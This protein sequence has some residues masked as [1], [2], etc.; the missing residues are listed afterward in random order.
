[1][2][3]GEQL[4]RQAVG[5]LV[6][7]KQAQVASPVGRSQPTAESRK[8]VWS[9]RPSRTW[10]AQPAS[11]SWARRSARGR[12]AAAARS[13]ARLRSP[14]RLRRDQVIAPE[15]AW[16]VETPGGTVP[17]RRAGT[18]RRAPQRGRPLRSRRSAPRARAPPRR[19]GV[20]PAR[21]WRESGW[22]LGEVATPVPRVAR[23]QTPSRAQTAAPT[24]RCARAQAAAAASTV[25]QT[26]FNDMPAS[27]A[28]VWTSGG[29]AQD[30]VGRFDGVT[31]VPERHN[32]PATPV[33]DPPR[34]IWSPM[35]RRPYQRPGSGNERYV[36]GVS[37]VRTTLAAMTRLELPCGDIQGPRAPSHCRPRA[38]RRRVPRR[39]LRRSGRLLRLSGFLITGLLL[40]EAR[41]N[42]SISLGGFYLRRARRSAG[43][44]SDA[45][46]NAGRGLL[47]PQLRPRKGSDVGQHLRRRLHGELSLRGAGDGLL[48]G[49]SAAVA[50]P[51]PLVT[52][53]REQFYLVWPALLSIVCLGSG[54]RW[55]PAATARSFGCCS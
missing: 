20:W 48:R 50:L 16:I 30:R 46:C 51:A 32:S 43:R 11:Q 17:A 21:A 47:P 28:L 5:E 26:T 22:S 31:D 10:A 54:R 36:S 53:R 18:D 44:R 23:P 1:M 19:R 27:R 45:P 52:R 41:A 34:P 42:G 24:R 40:S 14:G 39:G 29:K 7:T 37:D 9:S 35:A 12:S 38:R 49:G 13:A 4:A 33:T 6:E 2:G 15:S 55:S 8:R 25:H 3:V